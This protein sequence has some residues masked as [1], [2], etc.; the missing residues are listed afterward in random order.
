M[1]TH[2]LYTITMVSVEF[3]SRNVGHTTR[4]VFLIYGTGT[5]SRVGDGL[6]LYPR[7][8]AQNRANTY[9]FFTLR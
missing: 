2:E 8:R 6:Y 5:G 9:N 7:P 3:W 1:M 4:V